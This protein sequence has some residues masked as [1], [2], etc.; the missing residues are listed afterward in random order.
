M[1]ILYWNCKGL[2]NP[3]TQ[4]ALH[5]FCCSLRPTFLYLAE[6]KIVVDSIPYNYWRSLCLSFV[7]SNLTRLP[8]LWLLISDDIGAGTVDLF[9]SSEQH[10][11]VRWKIG[12]QYQFI[13]CIYANVLASIR[14][15]LW[16][17]L[18]HIAPLIS[19]SWF[20]IGDFNSCFGAHEKLGRPPNAR[21]CQEFAYA[22]A[23]CSISC[24]DTKGPLFTWTNKR[25]GPHIVDIHLNR[26]FCSDISFQVWSSIECNAL[27]HHCSD[28]NPI[29]LSYR[30]FASMHKP[31]RFLSIWTTHDKFLNSVREF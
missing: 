29:F 2:G 9:S 26:A 11:T 17:E 18:E 13:A 16:V 19:D 24:L 25:Q 10:I 15:H 6:P 4:C 28:H 7:A 3:A 12:N 27:A 21:S 5:N 20:V 14:C 22:M 30:Q 1:N 31:F 23:N 8:S